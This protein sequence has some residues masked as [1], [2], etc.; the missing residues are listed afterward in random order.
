MQYIY[1]EELNATAKT[2]IPQIQPI[3]KLKT[4]IQKLV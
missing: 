1:Y 4:S 2:E 3:P